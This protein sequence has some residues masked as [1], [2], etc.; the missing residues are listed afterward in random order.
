MEHLNAD[1]YNSIGWIL[2]DSDDGFYFVVASEKAQQEVVEQYAS[3]NIAIYDYKKSGVTYSFAGIYTFINANPN[4][5]AYFLQN[6]Q[7]AIRD[8]KDVQ[9]LN[10]SRDVLASLNKNIIFFVSQIV[11]D[12]LARG[13]LDFYSFI[14]LRIFFK[15]ENPEPLDNI[16]PSVIGFDRSVGIAEPDIDYNHPKPRI[17]SQAISLIN[18]SDQ[19]KKE[20]RYKDALTLLT[21]AKEIRDKVLGNEHPE[22]ASV[23]SKIADVY[24]AMGDYKEAVIWYFKTLAIREKTLGSEHAY[25]AMTY[26][27][28][29]N[30]YDDLGD[31]SKH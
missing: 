30:T 20:Y 16:T 9:R 19:L 2:N 25:T 21:K 24:Y 11:D 3:P 5:R 4:A 28:I 31:Y 18:Q 13:A 12:I 8:K 10:F 15:E 26:H 23:I 17:L 14:K 6:F 29:A 1:S 22:T 27:D 7:L